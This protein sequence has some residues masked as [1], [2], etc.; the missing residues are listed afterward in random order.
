[1]DNETIA[2]V[3]AESGPLDEGILGVV[4]I[5]NAEGKWLIRFENYDIIVDNVPEHGKLVFSIIIDGPAAGTEADAYKAM[6]AQNGL[7][8][9]TGG[10]RMA[11]AGDNSAIEISIDIPAALVTAN[12]VAATATGLGN[13]GAAWTQILGGQV[14]VN[15]PVASS[16]HTMIR[17]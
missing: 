3:I 14:D 17:A 4:G 8:R 1:M 6:L 9:E 5:E 16:D 11:L 7:W 2:A 12:I 10:V 15:E 13:F